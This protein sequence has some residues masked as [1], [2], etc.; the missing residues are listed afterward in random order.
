MFYSL[1][2]FPSL[3]KMNF[4]FYARDGRLHHTR[5]TH[6]EESLTCVY[7]CN[8]LHHQQKIQKWMEFFFTVSDAV[9]SSDGRFLVAKPWYPPREKGG[10][11]FV[12]G[13]C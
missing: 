9:F 12:T 5:K 3:W 2:H 8:L 4:Y 10:S 6:W 1:R 7:N 11:H 13:S